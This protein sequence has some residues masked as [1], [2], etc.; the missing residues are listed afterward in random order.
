MEQMKQRKPKPIFDRR[1]AFFTVASLILFAVVFYMLHSIAGSVAVKT[2]GDG[3]D[4]RIYRDLGN[5]L[6]SE[7]MYDQ[8]IS[9]YERYLAVASADNQTKSNIFY[10]IG[11][12]HFEKYRYEEAIAAYYM[13]DIMGPSELIRNDL[14]IKIVNCLERLGRGFSAEYALKSRTSVDLSA[15]KE[16]PEGTI[17][18]QYGDTYV[19]MRDLDEHLE[20]LPEEQRKEY[21]DPQKKFQFLQ[22]YL[23]TELLARKA[24][25]M[26]YD[27]DA[28]VMEQL[29]AVK[30]QLMIQKMVQAQF[31]DKVKVEPEDVRLYYDA[32][33]YKYTDPPAVQLAV[34]KTDSEEHAE[35]L[36]EQIKEG[37]DFSQAALAE[38]MDE[39][40][41]DKGGV[42]D[43]WLSP[44]NPV[45]A[46]EDRTHLI[47]T[48][49][50]LQE[51]ALSGVIEDGQGFFYIVKLIAKK[52]ERQKPYN[53]V[54]QQVA[55]DYQIFKGQRLYQEMMEDILKVE[56][57]QINHQAFFP[58]Q[59]DQQ[60][61]K[62]KVDIKPLNQFGQ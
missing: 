15:R 13:A 27:R 29:D 2:G 23:S 31:K 40:T 52:L 30:K 33:K 4:A 3:I 61:R 20:K 8:A 42:I 25:K 14:N 50:E 9:A 36:L 22:Q 34:I 37:M 62:P 26:G 60:N 41:K 59:D 44:D 56:G 49:M 35:D 5:K 12:L 28:D 53:E 45:S 51:G 17:V 54:V 6:K 18:A 16:K 43:Q 10:L 19:S 48:A 11:D 32:N 47:R 58:Q 46:G 24:T 7:K 57:V 38:S 1:T 39:T 21:R 55:Q